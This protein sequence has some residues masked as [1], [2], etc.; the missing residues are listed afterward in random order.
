MNITISTAKLDT[1]THENEDATVH[2]TT[3]LLAAFSNL[4]PVFFS[5]TWVFFREHSRITRLQGNGEGISFTPHYH[6]HPLRRQL[7]FSRAI[8]PESSPLH[9]AGNR[10]RTGNLW[11]PSSSR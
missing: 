6:T 9:I 5:T 3:Q 8:T 10:T 7:E 4:W 1:L 2:S 11:F